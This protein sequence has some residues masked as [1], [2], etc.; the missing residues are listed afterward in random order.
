MIKVS[1]VKRVIVD[2]TVAEKAIAHPTDSCLLERRREYLAEP[3][4]R[5]GP[6]QPLPVSPWDLADL[7]C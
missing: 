3:A 7:R 6:R 5:H 1:S 4:S 2:T